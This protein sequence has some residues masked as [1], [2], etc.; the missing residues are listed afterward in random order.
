MGY[1]GLLLIIGAFIGIF[2]LN[3]AAG[4][5]LGKKKRCPRCGNY[6]ATPNGGGYY[7]DGKE[8]WIGYAIIAE[9]VF[10]DR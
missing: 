8:V 7:R 3:N 2:A 10:S 1:L 5:S 4:K 6:G 9:I